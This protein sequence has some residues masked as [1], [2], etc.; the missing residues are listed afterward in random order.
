MIEH[1][2]VSSSATMPE[3]QA[4][5]GER[6]EAELT[7]LAAH[8]H[9]GMCRFLLM[10]AEFDRRELYDGWECGGTAQWLSW[11]CGIAPRT[12]REQVHVARSYAKV[13]AMAR[14]IDVVPED[15]LIDM[16]AAATAGQLERILGCF[17][18]HH[19]NQTQPPRAKQGAVPLRT[20]GVGG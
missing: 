5:A 14:V 3:L 2:F 19:K 11:K 17:N 16:A 8:L 4:L 18:R 7:T 13:R 9:A 15:E 12:A 6:L 10:V 1:V 20:A